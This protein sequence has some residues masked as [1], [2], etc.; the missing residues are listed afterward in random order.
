M[1]ETKQNGQAEGRRTRLKTYTSNT[2]IH[3]PTGY[4][5]GKRQIKHDL[6]KNSKIIIQQYPNTYKLN[7][8]I[9]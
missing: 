6:I 5:W 9:I 3:I 2:N 4:I 8:H 7:I 1:A